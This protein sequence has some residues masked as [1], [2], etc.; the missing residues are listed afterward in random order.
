MP[1]VSLTNVK[2]NYMLGKV[3]VPALKGINMEIEEGILF[4]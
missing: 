2:K 1:I 4:P 3:E